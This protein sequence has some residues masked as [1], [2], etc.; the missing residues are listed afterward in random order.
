MKFLHWKNVRLCLWLL[1]VKIVLLITINKKNFET[2]K[3]SIVASIQL[4]FEKL[5][6][7]INVWKVI[8]KKIEFPL[9]PFQNGMSTTSIS[10]DIWYIGWDVPLSSKFSKD[11]LNT[12]YSTIQPSSFI[13][14]N[15]R[16]T[17]CKF[18]HVRFQSSVVDLLSLELCWSFP[19]DFCP[20]RLHSRISDN[21][22]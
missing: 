3:S 2:K 7:I 20:F 5:F 10:K 16:F 1:K 19:F 4:L 18:V 8:D 11:S 6:R 21:F 15:I 22:R 14:G 9:P 12:N 13:F 17:S